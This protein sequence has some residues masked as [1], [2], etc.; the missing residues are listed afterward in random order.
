MLR[1]ET[2]GE[3]KLVGI[4]P[5]EVSKTVQLVLF[6]VIMRELRY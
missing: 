4:G 3:E 2:G 5:T 1:L 6:C